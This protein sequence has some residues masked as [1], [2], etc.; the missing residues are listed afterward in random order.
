MVERSYSY[1]VIV[2]V[3]V[4]TITGD[5]RD[6]PL[7]LPL[8]PSYGDGGS[9]GATTDSTVR[10]AKIGRRGDIDISR[11]DVYTPGIVFSVKSINI[12]LYQ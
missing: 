1:S 10:G 5:D 8:L 9:G 3:P 11:S 12:L 7:Q 4:K 6:H 2:I